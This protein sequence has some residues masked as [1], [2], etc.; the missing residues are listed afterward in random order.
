ME[1]IPDGVFQRILG[2]MTSKDVASIAI[3]ST[4]MA[5]MV[6]PSSYRHIALSNTS[7]TNNVADA[8]RGGECES[9]TLDLNENRDTLNALLDARSVAVRHITRITLLHN[10]PSGVT[11]ARLLSRATFPALDELTVEH[12]FIDATFSTALTDARFACDHVLMWASDLPLLGS[13]HVRDVRLSLDT[14]HSHPFATAAANGLR[15]DAM[16]IVDI[17]EVDNLTHARVAQIFDHIKNI[18]ATF[19]VANFTATTQHM[20]FLHA[21]SEAC[22]ASS[23]LTI[24]ADPDAAR[25]LLSLTNTF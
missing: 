18:A 13:R 15:I 3:S 12:G 20:Q 24:H 25:F 8:L 6:R 23:R 19:S 10:L 16:S 9:L 5:A 7:S 22:G 2:F 14:V 11:L 17:D 21:C 1:G 4:C